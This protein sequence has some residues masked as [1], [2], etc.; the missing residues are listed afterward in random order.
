MYS[1]EKK[2]FYKNKLIWKLE[3][4]KLDS[5]DELLFDSLD[6]ATRQYLLQ[7]T[8][9]ETPPVIVFFGGNELWTFI[10]GLEVVSMHSGVIHRILLDDIKKKI[11]VPPKVKQGETSK[12]TF[13]YLTLGD[14]ALKIWAPEGKVIFALM[15]ILQMFPLRDVKSER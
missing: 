8:S 15:N 7:Y 2:G 6:G 3:R 11:R 13:N 12:M 5:S 10:S 1:I 9:P 14:D 4:N